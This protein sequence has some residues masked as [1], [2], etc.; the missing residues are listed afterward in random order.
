[1][2]SLGEGQAVLSTTYFTLNS[3]CV[4]PLSR[5]YNSGLIN[6]TS[7]DVCE[8]HIM[9]WLEWLKICGRHRKYI[10][11]KWYIET[12]IVNPA[13]F[14]LGM[15]RRA[16]LPEKCQV[17]RRL[18]SRTCFRTWVL[19]YPPRGPSCAYCTIKFPS[20][21]KIGLLCFSRKRGRCPNEI[22]TSLECQNVAS[23]YEA[24]HCLGFGARCFL[25]SSADISQS[26]RREAVGKFN[27]Q[28]EYYIG[29]FLS[30]LIY[31]FYDAKCQSW[32]IF[33]LW[34]RYFC[35]L[36]PRELLRGLFSG[37]IW[38]FDVFTTF[39]LV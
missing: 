5:V 30:M 17:I 15:G 25:G 1:M 38:Y 22:Q 2:K 7:K 21:W 26:S 9:S 36:V 34:I 27:K 14:Y 33:C 8:R 3:Y 4:L 18:F 10:S 35:L 28:R 16:T 29:Q 6:H 31:R 37:Y 24:S 19:I 39:L 32:L 23:G 11:S 12:G 20:T 13:V